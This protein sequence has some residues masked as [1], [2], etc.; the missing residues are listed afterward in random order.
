MIWS[1]GRRV[2]TTPKVWTNGRNPR[3]A[4]AP[5]MLI[6]LASAMPPWM[7]RSGICSWNRSISV[8]RVKSPVRHRISGRLR[9]RS[10]SARPYG[11][12]TV[13]YGCLSKARLQLLDGRLCERGR[14]LD[15][16]AVGAVR[17]HRQPAGGRRA[18]DDH[19]GPRVGGGGAPRLVDGG[20][21]MPVQAEGGPAEALPF[22]GD[23]LQGG[24][25]RDRAVDLRVVGV[26]EDGER[27]E[28]VVR[29]EQRRLP[30]LPLLQLAVADD[31]EHPRIGAPLQPVGQGEPGGPGQAH[32][33]RAAGEVD[34]RRTLGA[35]RLQRGVVEAVGRQRL[36]VEQACLR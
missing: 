36:L 35:D 33:E 34:G 11:L 2:A 31:R 23:G 1:S 28:P 22:R 15:E 13:G 5:A 29:G 4:R 7:K 10:T 32:A 6:R 24:D 21:V 26:E 8:W 30:D 3:R 12:M 14:Q 25:R 16:V 19:G 9:A 27:S 20:A 17:Q 18:P